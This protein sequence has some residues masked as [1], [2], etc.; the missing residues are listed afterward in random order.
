ME[1]MPELRVVADEQILVFEGHL[2]R[3]L[4]VIDEDIVMAGIQGTD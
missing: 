1:G 4:A 3:A 2:N